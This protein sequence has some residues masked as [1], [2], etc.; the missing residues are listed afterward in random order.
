MLYRQW[1]SDSSS[2]EAYNSDTDKEE[3]PSSKPLS[4]YRVKPN[5]RARA[6]QK[7][8]KVPSRKKRFSSSDEEST[9]ESEDESSK[10]WISS[11]HLKGNFLNFIKSYGQLSIHFYYV[12]SL[13][14]FLPNQNALKTH[15]DLLGLEMFLYF[16]WRSFGKLSFICLIQYLMVKKIVHRLLFI[17]VCRILE[18]IRVTNSWYL[19]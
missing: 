9:P 12:P 1:N 17:I 3:I 5:L 2:S 18:R 4:R 7:Q 16:S 8:K 6:V 19:E 11:L 15:C 14:F 13:L 10:R